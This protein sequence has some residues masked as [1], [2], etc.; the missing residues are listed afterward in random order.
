MEIR[1]KKFFIL[2]DWVD[3][4]HD[5]YTLFKASQELIRAVVVHLRLDE[6]FTNALDCKRCALRVGK[7]F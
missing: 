7:L 5:H 3:S 4:G 2:S 1:R 6:Q